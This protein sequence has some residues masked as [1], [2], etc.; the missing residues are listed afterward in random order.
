MQCAEENRP[1]APC[2]TCARNAISESVTCEVC[3]MPVHFTCEKLTKEETDRCENGAPYTCKS[4]FKLS[5]DDI[6]YQNIAAP[7]AALQPIHATDNHPPTSPTSPTKT[8]NSLPTGPAPADNSHPTTSTNTQ[9]ALHGNHQN[10]VSDI[11]HTTIKAIVT[12]DPTHANTCQTNRSIQKAQ[13]LSTTARS[14]QVAIPRPTHRNLLP[15]TPHVQTNPNVDDPGINEADL[16]AR[17]KSLNRREKHLKKLEM[18]NAEYTKQQAAIRAHLFSEETKVR[19]LEEEIRLLKIQMRCMPQQQPGTQYS[20]PPQNFKHPVHS[21]GPSDAI[22][23]QL[24]IAI[25]TLIAAINNLPMK[26]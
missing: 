12:T 8:D 13:S 7:Q 18:E 11:P 3:E 16:R 15:D 14:K 23:L 22:N 2:K 4:C 25:T 26:N 10:S 9:I 6:T 19:S 5:N 20:M 24:L 17:E 1:E 21:Q